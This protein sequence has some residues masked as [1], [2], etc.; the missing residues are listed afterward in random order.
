M[1]FRLR[2]LIGC[3]VKL[4]LESEKELTADVCFVGS[5][6][7]ELNVKKIKH[8][9]DSSKKK[10]KKKGKKKSLNKSMIVPFEAI[11]SLELK[12]EC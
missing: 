10:S 2:Q 5:N 3:E 8:N 12:T 11:R 4:S 7:V 6:F 9:S 1:N